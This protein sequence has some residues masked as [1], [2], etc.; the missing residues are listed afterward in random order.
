MSLRNVDHVHLLA[1]DQLN[2][3][4]VLVSDEVVFTRAAL[5]SLVAS[6]TGAQE[7]SR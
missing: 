4:D 6:A 7:E 3:Y 5:D 2:T 1:V